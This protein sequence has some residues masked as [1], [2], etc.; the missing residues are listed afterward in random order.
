M[1]QKHVE[2]FA[3][4]ELAKSADITE[5]GMTEARAEVESAV[6]VAKRY[7]RDEQAA[8]ELAM[9]RCSRFGFAE[10]G[11]YSFPRGG[12]QIEGPSVNLAR[13]LATAYGNMRYGATVIRD[14]D[15]R[16]G[17]RA[18]AWDIQSNTY[19]FAETEFKKLIQRKVGK[20][21]NRKTE[22]VKPDER[23]LRELTNKHAAIL[24]R[25]CILQVVPSDFVED[26][27]VRCR[28]TV[29]EKVKGGK[30]KMLQRVVDAF[31]KLKVT[32]QDICKRYG[33]K[34]VEELNV[35]QIVELRGIYRAVKDGA[36]PAHQAFQSRE[37]SV[38]EIELS[39]EDVTV[40]DG[41]DVDNRENGDGGDRTNP[42]ESE[43]GKEVI[44]EIPD[45]V[46]ETE[47]DD[48]VKERRARAEEVVA[49]VE[50]LLKSPAKDL[51][52]DVYDEVA[53][54]TGF[55]PDEHST[56]EY[57]QYLAKR[58]WKKMIAF[59]KDWFIETYLAA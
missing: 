44:P 54:M 46:G 24:V 48:S 13:G 52:K 19:V 8:Y 11:Y 42:P 56:A 27:Y 41:E 45:G 37:K 15:E 20:G 34:K 14:T 26:A 38:A 1:T 6:V 31:A 30:S 50:E 18:F 29:T 55:D 43:A 5:V 36:I 9:T 58:N 23:D 51:S 17:V 25:N 21:R 40:D 28:E 47:D 32:P 7:P 3:G 53:R 59:I 12:T 22:W 39:V 4:T 2:K 10:K 57:R 33:I 49:F 35:P 16:R